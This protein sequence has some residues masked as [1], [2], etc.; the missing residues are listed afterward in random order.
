M[1]TDEFQQLNFVEREKVAKYISVISGKNP[2]TV[3]CL[4]HHYALA[5][6]SDRACKSPAL[7]M[8]R[9]FLY[10]VPVDYNK[11]TNE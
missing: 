7:L 1:T 3:M 10:W 4:A 5:A 2:E 6:R 9:H 8:F 11:I